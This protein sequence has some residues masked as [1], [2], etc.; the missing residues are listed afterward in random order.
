MLMFV[1][2][3]LLLEVFLHLTI[4][5][6]ICPLNCTAFPI[7]KHSRDKSY[8]SSSYSFISGCAELDS[9]LSKMLASVIS[10]IGL[11]ICY[12]VLILSSSDRA[13]LT[14][15]NTMEQHSVAP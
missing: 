6:P 7:S 1:Y 15:Q 8:L 13:M 11:P 12:P 3:V 10:A 9:M 4:V 14:S 2:T 5:S